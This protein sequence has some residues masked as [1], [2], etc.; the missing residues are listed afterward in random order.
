MKIVVEFEITYADIAGYGDRGRDRTL[1]R[2]DAEAWE[3]NANASI[4]SAEPLDR[5]DAG[6]RD[7]RRML[8]D[9]I[10]LVQ[11][12]NRPAAIYVRFERLDGSDGLLTGSRRLQFLSDLR[13]ELLSVSS[14]RE[15]GF[16]FPPFL[17]TRSVARWSRAATP[18]R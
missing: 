18:L 17:A 11:T 2:V 9:D 4:L 8:V 16:V 7:D 14:R 12:Q 5:M 6:E 3:R 15:I 13:L 1:L 10:Q